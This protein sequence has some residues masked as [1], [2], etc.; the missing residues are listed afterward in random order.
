MLNKGLTI[1]YFT[2]S[3]L[4]EKNLRSADFSARYSINFNDKTI[5]CLKQLFSKNLISPIF[6]NYM[7]LHRRSTVII[8]SWL[9]RVAVRFLV[10]D[11]LRKPLRS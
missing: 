8:M 11:A 4:P 6:K 2:I 10:S 5:K 9:K 7:K 1:A 3:R